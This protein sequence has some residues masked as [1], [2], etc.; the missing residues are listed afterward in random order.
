MNTTK[1][2]EYNY[3]MI[4]LVVYCYKNNSKLFTE[5]WIR[6]IFQVKKNTNLKHFNINERD[7]SFWKSIE[8]KIDTSL[9]EGTKRIFTCALILGKNN[10]ILTQK[11]WVR[12]SIFWMEL[13]F[14]NL[15]NVF[16]IG[17]SCQCTQWE[18]LEEFYQNYTT[19]KYL[20]FVWNS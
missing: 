8:N 2:C 18:T 4:N 14:S 9:I 15:K 7:I 16:L 1:W 5:I 12:W 6:Y 19:K 10:I 20:P 17:F 3:S 13:G 11:T